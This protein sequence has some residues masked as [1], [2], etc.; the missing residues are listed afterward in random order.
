MQD[1]PALVV[2]DDDCEV[3]GDLPSPSR[4]NQKEQAKPK[5][6]KPQKISLDEKL[7]AV[8]MHRLL[9]LLP[10]D[11]SASLHPAAVTTLPK[12][13]V[14]ILQTESGLYFFSLPHPKLVQVCPPPL[15]PVSLPS[16]GHRKSLAETRVLGLW[17]AANRTGCTV[18]GIFCPQSRRMIRRLFTTERL[19]CPSVVSFAS[20]RLVAYLTTT[21]AVVVIPLDSL[22]PIVRPLG[23]TLSAYLDSTLAADTLASLAFEGLLVEWIDLQELIVLWGKWTRVPFLCVFFKRHMA[24]KLA[25]FDLLSAF[26]TSVEGVKLIP[27]RFFKAQ[28][29]ASSSGRSRSSADL[30][31]GVY[32]HG[33]VAVYRLRE[34]AENRFADL[35]SPS[36]SLDHI[37]T[38]H[39]D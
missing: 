17:P 19:Y 10:H 22:A 13:R 12:A 33:R 39:L 25:V 30:Y 26:Q 4:I 8:H 34:M 1:Q 27:S 29:G 35:S 38:Q 5:K 18:L 9:Q 31:L 7:F 23:P 24:L 6:E 36:H 20:G 37:V 21:H 3:V 16:G 2:E 28:E 11:A 14:Q 32:A 15:G